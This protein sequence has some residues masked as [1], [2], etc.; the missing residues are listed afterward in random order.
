MGNLPVLRSLATLAYDCR[1]S[2]MFRGELLAAL[3]IIDRGDLQASDMIGSWAGELGQTQFLPTHYLK[4]AV[5][6]DGDGRRDLLKSA[7]DVVASTAAFIQS[8]GWERGQPWLQEVRVPTNLAWDQ[9]DLAIKHPRSQ[10]VKWGVTLADGRPLP[11]DALPA[12]LLLMMGRNGPAFLAYPNFQVYLQWNQSLTYATTAGYL[13]TRIAGAPIM[14]RGK[15]VSPSL[16]GEQVKDL[17]SAL[18]R[19]GHLTGEADGKLGAGSRAAV[20]KAQIKYGLPADS[21]PTTELLE[22]LRRK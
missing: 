11:N 1:R 12:S 19:Q 17:Q 10:W 13:A 7:P 21:Y 6:F 14:F 16:S 2:E 18:I 20:K 8:L 15:G 3:Q 5:D 9:A 4:H 22:R